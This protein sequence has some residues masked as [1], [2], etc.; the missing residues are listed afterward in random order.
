MDNGF[1][2]SFNGRM[3]GECLSESL[4]LDFDHTRTKIATWADDNNRHLPHS[5]FGLLTPLGYAANLSARC[6]RL[7]NP[8]QLHRS[9]VAAPA[10]QGVK[11]AESKIAAG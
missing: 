2:G 10:P 3:H 11:P 7:R 1:R 4:F 8:D 9:H 6:Y 5:A